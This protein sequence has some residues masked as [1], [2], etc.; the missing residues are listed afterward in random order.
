[1]WR[2]VVAPS[3]LSRSS[4]GAERRS[5]SVRNGRRSGAGFRA[6][7]GIVLPILLLTACRTTI[8]STLQS[9]PTPAQLAELWVEPERNRD[10]FWGVG[11]RPLAPDP[12]A[13]Y[14]VIDMKRGGFS[15]GYTV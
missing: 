10:L 9:P 8:Q 14:T 1:S 3:Q 2:T 13:R 5:G 12:E 11:G 6:I 4:A 7:S 15:R